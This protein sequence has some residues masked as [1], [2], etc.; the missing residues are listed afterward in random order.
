MKFRT[1]VLVLVLFA[2]TLSAQTV[3]RG[4]NEG[5]SNIPASNVAGHGNITVGS[6]LMGG[7]FINGFQS[8]ASASMKVGIGNNL[9]LSASS[10]FPGLSS[11]GCISS[12]LQITLP[13]NDRL[14]FLGMSAL[15][16][17]YLSMEGDTISAS[18]R[19]GKPD[20]NS[21]IIPSCVV[22]L[23][24][25]SL[26]N[27]FPLKLYGY[28]SL[29]DAP[30]LLFRYDQISFRAAVEWKLYKHSY[31]VD[32]GYGLYK[33][34]RWN[35]LDGDK[36]YEQRVMW[37]EPGGRMRLGEGFSV[38]GS[39]RL[40]MF[41]DV[42]LVNGLEPAH[43]QAQ[44]GLEMPL[45]YKETKTEAVRSLIFIEQEEI[46]QKD[47]ISRNI[48]QRE[49]FRM[50]IDPFIDEQADSSSTTKEDIRK[51]REEIDAKMREIEQLLQ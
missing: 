3:K 51:R 16:Q 30:E 23:D 21:F 12:S 48:E 44:V 29:A 17:L 38:L 49:T 19:Q 42:K 46:R 41:N 34:K 35:N 45:L 32:L 20:Y 18:A 47:L 13:G 6:G 1:E 5:T 4:R 39:L 8:Q 22:D 40:L 43:F 14:R 11:F 33:Q 25:I 27:T 2:F 24:F 28:F 10:S 31:Y 9:Q 36:K 50:K 15:G 26:F 37:V 7:V